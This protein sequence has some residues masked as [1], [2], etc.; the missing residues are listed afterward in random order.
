[1][2]ISHFKLSVKKKKKECQIQQLYIETYSV[3]NCPAWLPD[4]SMLKVFIMILTAQRGENEWLGF[5]KLPTN[6]KAS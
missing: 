3:F 2:K 1:M 6:V 4:T 5:W